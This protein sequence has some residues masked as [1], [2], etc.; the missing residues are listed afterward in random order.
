MPIIHP[1]HLERFEGHGGIMCGL[2]TPSQGA[3]ELLLWRATMHVGA[4]SQPQY[5]DHE[6]IVF[7]LQGEGLAHL[8]GEVF[9][10]AAGDTL[11]FPASAV[12][13]VTNTGETP[14]DALILLPVGTS[15]FLPDG[16]KL[17]APAWAR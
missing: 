5:H 8:A 11:I 13:Q 15:S 14:L 9:P 7:I 2:A 12:H 4:S 1:T 17:P 3:T 6:E 16:E 10:F